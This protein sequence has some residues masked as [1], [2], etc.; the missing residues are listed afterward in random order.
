M[1]SRAES[2]IDMGQ[3][4]QLQLINA[5]LDALDLAA[6]QM[7]MRQDR[8]DS[9]LDRNSTLLLTSAV[10]FSAAAVAFA[11]NFLR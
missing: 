1:T 2:R 10:G 5:D 4:K 6:T 8:Q 9:R 3:D 11:L 7:A